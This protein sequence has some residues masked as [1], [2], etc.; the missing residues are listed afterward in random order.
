MTETIPLEAL[1]FLA[2]L[3]PSLFVAVLFPYSVG[4][5]RFS[6]VN[7]V[8]E[9]SVATSLDRA[10]V[11]RV[12]VNAL[13]EVF[14]KEIVVVS[15][16]FTESVVV[17]LLVVPVFVLGVV[18]TCEDVVVVRGVPAVE[19]MVELIVTTAVE[20]FCFVEA[21]EVVVTAI[22]EE[23]EYVQKINSHC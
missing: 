1:S 17:I 6:D 10:V 21:M 8:V 14:L 19:A 11:S 4:G 15:F 3:T 20:S 9:G 7:S 12:V 13:V 5:R 18:V 16:F 22:R 2:S 23:R